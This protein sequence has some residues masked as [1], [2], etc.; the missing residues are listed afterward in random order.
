MLWLSSSAGKANISLT[1]DRAA[2]ED[3]GVHLNPSFAQG[4]A[5]PWVY[6]RTHILARQCVNQFLPSLLSSQSIHIR[7]LYSRH[8]F[9]Q[10]EYKMNGNNTGL[11][12]VSALVLIAAI[13]YSSRR[14]E[15]IHVT[16]TP[17]APAAKIEATVG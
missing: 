14:T 17:A 6:F 11:R 4:S 1:P 10:K 12:I 5:R 8:K 13:I 16:S 2:S 15:G 7:I 3:F 9:K